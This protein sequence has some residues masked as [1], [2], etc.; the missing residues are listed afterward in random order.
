MV[1][2]FAFKRESD[3]VRKVSDFEFRSITKVFAVNL[4][5]VRVNFM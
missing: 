3:K 4:E 1:W 5:E 2:L